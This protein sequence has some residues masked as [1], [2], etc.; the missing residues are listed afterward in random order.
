M[1][2]SRTAGTTLKSNRP[3]A[4]GWPRSWALLLV[5]PFAA[6]R[7]CTDTD[8]NT[9][10]ASAEALVAPATAAAP[11][12]N[13]SV[14][15]CDDRGAGLNL[16][17]RSGPGE[18][19]LWLPVEWGGGYFVLGQ[20]RAASGSRYEGDDLMLWIHGEE[21]LVEVA[22]EQH[23]GCRLDVHQSIWAHARL[24]GVLFRGVGNE[25]GWSIEIRDRRLDLELDYGT[26]T[27]SVDVDREQSLSA[28]TG[29]GVREIRGVHG[30]ETVLV[31]ISESPCNDSMSGEPF[32]A[33]VV[34][35][36]G[37]RRLHGCGN[38]LNRAEPHP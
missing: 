10:A 9:P 2:I 14:Y 31:E 20:V 5:V 16:I 4:A 25:P 36:L 17:T 12:R 15:V 23:R 22:G 37:A 33:T 38:W 1:T 35:H 30:T 6:T 8:L 18:I 29:A 3:A 11:R 28:S 27:L 7:G 24:S 34:T 19:A 21:A 32:D 26:R 13:T